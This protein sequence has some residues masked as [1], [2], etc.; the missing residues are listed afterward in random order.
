MSTPAPAAIPAID[1]RAARLRRVP[2][3]FVSHGSPLTVIDKD[4][5]GAIHKFTARQ[6][7]L[8]AIV[9]VSAHWQTSGTIHVTSSPKPPLIYDFVGFPGWLYEIAYACPGDRAV[10]QAVAVCLERAGLAAR[11]DP[12]RGLDHGVWVPLSVAFPEAAIP[13]VQVSLPL[14]STTEALFA[15]GRALSPLRSEDI[16][17]VGSGGIVHDL[18]HLHM[19]MAD[20]TAEPWAVEF[21]TWVR[22]KAGSLDLT[23]LSGYERL[24]PHARVAV[25]TSEHFDPLLFVMG[26]ALPGDSLYDLYEGF[27]YGTLSL[28]SFAL[29]GRRREDRGF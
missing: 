15:M 19:D 29:T 7:R 23:A 3:L 24:G 11:L 20:G 17:L 18:A 13:V 6:H 5:A 27:R 21:D 22:D 12:D 1:R 10:A 28:R 25:P 16:L 26:T 9:V 2:S 8:R 4:Y 14:P